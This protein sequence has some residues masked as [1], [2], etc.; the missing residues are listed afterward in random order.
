MFAIIAIILLIIWGGGLA[1]H[2]LGAFIYIFL[3]LAA[4]SGIAHLLTGG[5]NAKLNS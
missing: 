5:K 3:V 1:L 4:I 2:L